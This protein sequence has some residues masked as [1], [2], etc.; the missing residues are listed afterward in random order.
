MN[1]EIEKI[2]EKLLNLDFSEVDPYDLAKI[3]FEECNE[4]SLFEPLKTIIPN[5][6]YNTLLEW[7]PN[8]EELIPLVD[9]NFFEY[10]RQKVLEANGFTMEEGYH[11]NKNNVIDVQV[12]LYQ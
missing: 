9:Q 2:H 8:N 1:F 4:Q 12:Y 10:M 7:F 11:A 6:L 3:L 5:K